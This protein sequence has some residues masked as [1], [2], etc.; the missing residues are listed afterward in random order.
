VLEDALGELSTISV[1]EEHLV[2][3]RCPVDANILSLIGHLLLRLRAHRDLLPVPVL[4][5]GK[6][7][8]ADSPRGIDHGQSDGAQVPPRC[9]E[10]QG[11]HGC[12]R[13]SARSWKLPRLAVAPGSRYTVARPRRAAPRTAWK[14][15]RG[16]CFRVRRTRA[17]ATDRVPT[18]A[19]LM[20]RRV[21]PYSA[22][23]C[24]LWGSPWHSGDPTR[25]RMVSKGWTV[26]R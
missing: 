26:E 7:S 1:G 24:P 8:G 18:L 20:H 11:A 21:L 6:L 25:P 16:P 12:S 10:P 5:L 22:A 17:G 15:Y 23:R 19:V 9:S 3:T 14:G 2:T 4:A 13:E